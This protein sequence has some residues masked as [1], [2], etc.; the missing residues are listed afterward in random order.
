MARA[1]EQLASGLA[2]GHFGLGLRGGVAGTVRQ[3]VHDGDT[4]N[5]RALGNFGI[6]FLG[7][8]TP[9]ISLPL[10]G[11]RAFIGIS[12]ARW[13]AFL[14]D[15]FDAA[16]PSFSPALE[17][18][19]LAHLQTRT[20][21]GAAL[22]H[23]RHA[24]AAEDGLEEEVENDVAVLGETEETF[25]FFLAFAHE[26][27]DRYG[28]L[29]AYINRDQPSQD[30]PAP[31]PKTYNERL[32]TRGLASPYFIWPNINPFRKQ[33]SL[34]EAVPA[35]GSAATVADSER[36]LTEARQAVQQARLAGEGIF[37]DGD[38]LRLEAFEVRYLASRRPP[39]R[40]VIDLSKNEDVLIRP[41]EYHTVPNA[42]DRLFIPDEF[43]PLFV[44]RGWRLPA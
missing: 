14:T 9:E 39:A 33:N 26:V 20:G 7:V 22:N 16:L 25:R 15:P 24:A 12:N 17:V 11:G 1:V 31:R 29:L 23:A 34:R 3:Q 43:V 42:E 13:E 10:P 2:V 41:Q 35:P 36:T 21:A 37:A 5:A 30:Q 19:L 28:R 6:R 18:G 4:I 8:D 32:L 38:P 27:M 40:W 44:D